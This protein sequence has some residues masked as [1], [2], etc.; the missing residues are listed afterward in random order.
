MMRRFVR[1]SARTGQGI[2][3][4]KSRIRAYAGKTEEEKPDEARKKEAPARLPVDTVERCVGFGTVVTGTMLEGQIE[5]GQELTVF[6][7]EKNM[8]G[9]GHTGLWKRGGYL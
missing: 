5:K 8:P 3:E 9:A 6:P 4:L 1:V 2:D 7:E